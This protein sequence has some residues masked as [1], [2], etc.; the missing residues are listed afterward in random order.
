[1]SDDSQNQSSLPAP[2]SLLADLRQMILA[3]R[4]RVAVAVNAE[5]TMLYWHI[6]ERI[7]MEVLQEQRAEYGRQ[8][9]EA[10]AA[11]LT[12]QFGKGFDRANLFRMMQ[13]AEQ[14][15]DEQIV[16][17]LSRQLSWYHS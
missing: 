17:T 1:M 6:G 5:L 14:V 9:V 2:S 7:R 15:P 8:I 10:V 3:A 4:E 13:F 12:M 11:E 16:A